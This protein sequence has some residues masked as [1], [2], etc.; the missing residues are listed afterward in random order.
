MEKDGSVRVE[1]INPGAANPLEIIGL[2]EKVKSEI[3]MA[4]REKEDL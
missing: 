4:M 1:S 3:V 2:L